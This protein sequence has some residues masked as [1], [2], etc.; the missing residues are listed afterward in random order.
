M[1]NNQLEVEVLDRSYFESD[2]HYAKYNQV[3]KANQEDYEIRTDEERKT[4]THALALLNIFTKNKGAKIE[5][6]I[7]NYDKVEEMDFMDILMSCFF[8]DEM[9]GSFYKS[10]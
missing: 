5:V 9:F 3:L 10:E 8:F 7:D 6:A 1:E 2:E 4:L